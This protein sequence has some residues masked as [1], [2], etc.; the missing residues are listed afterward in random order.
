MTKKLTP[1]DIADQI[2]L[3]IRQLDKAQDLLKERSEK[4]AET[5]ADY[6]KAVAV[7]LIGLRNGKSYELNGVAI[8]DPPAS[9]ME[10]VARGIC[11]QEKLNMDLAEGQYKSLITG[12][13]MIQS[14][15][16]GWQSIYKFQ[17][18]K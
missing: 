5:S 6:D 15:L 1:I 12:I 18:E 16:M 9:I 3:K 13:E 8:Q 10:K 14:Q 4:R 7:V 2:E 11:W 17:S